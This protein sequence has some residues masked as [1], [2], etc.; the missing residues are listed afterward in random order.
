[1]ASHPQRHGNVVEYAEV[2]IQRIGLEHH[3]KIAGA[4]TNP[5][6]G[7][8]TDANFTRCLGLETGN[9]AQQCRLAA[10]GGTDQ[11]DELAVR[12][13]KIN[14]LQDLRRVKDLADGFQFDLCH[15]GRAPTAMQQR[16]DD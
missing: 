10:A 12:D 6:D 2:R 4:G 1:M 16:A 5:V 7:H 14:P 13:R 15:F 8:V 11:R 9:D 3:R